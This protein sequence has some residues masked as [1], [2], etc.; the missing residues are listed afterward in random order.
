MQTLL[1]THPPSLPLSL[2]S[3]TFENAISL[4]S[5]SRERIIVPLTVR[6]TRPH[7]A[8][9]R[10]GGECVMLYTT[11]KGGQGGREGGRDRE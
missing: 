4:S 6:K 8:G 5:I 10:R 3:I 1:R 9:M 7:M 11:W 2:P